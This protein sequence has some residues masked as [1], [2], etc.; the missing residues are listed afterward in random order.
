M[1][2]NCLVLACDI[3]L[4]GQFES[5]HF[6]RRCF[7]KKRANMW[8]C[9]FVIV[10]LGTKK[11]GCI[12][13][14]IFDYRRDR[15]RTTLDAGARPGSPWA[16]DRCKV[17]PK[18]QTDGT[19]KASLMAFDSCSDRQFHK[20]NQTLMFHHSGHRFVLEDLKSTGYAWSQV[21]VPCCCLI[22]SEDGGSKGQH[23]RV[24]KMHANAH[25]SS[26]REAPEQSILRV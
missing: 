11:G 9:D 20:V 6:Q 1:L 5:T 10:G 7:R 21:G 4:G 18:S 14:C 2:S 19:Q 24:G 8:K 17:P 25:S 13:N 15:V 3:G 26:T 22:F 12:L 23:L 16:L